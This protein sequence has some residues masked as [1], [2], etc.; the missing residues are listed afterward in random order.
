MSAER[1]ELW[2]RIQAAIDRG[3]EPLD[4]PAVVAG[5]ESDPVGLEEYARVVEALGALPLA[6]PVVHRRPP[7]PVARLCGGL[8]A[9]A[10]LAWLLLPARQPEA[11]LPHGDPLR[12]LHLSVVH[13]TPA[14]ESR[15]ERLEG[16]SRLARVAH[17]TGGRV[18]RRVV[19]TTERK[20][21]VP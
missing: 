12:I 8:A 16:G 5:L 10:A 21:E 18:L 6:R 14:G 7:L 19:E 1:A 9:A 17:A 4:D 11:R 2:A 20:N 13:A 15:F 3:D